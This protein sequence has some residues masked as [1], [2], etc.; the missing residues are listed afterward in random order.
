MDTNTPQ[1]TTYKAVP[2]TGTHTGAM[3]GKLNALDWIALVLMIV[4]AINWGL[5]GAVNFDLVAFLFGPMSAVSRV[6]YVLVG[7]GGLYGLTMP[8]RLRP[9][10]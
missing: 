9:S 10:A 7:I 2:V 4:G 6:I 3:G 1:P 8:L 5:V